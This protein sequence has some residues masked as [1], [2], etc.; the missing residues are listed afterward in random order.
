MGNT[1]KIL[2]VN[3]LSIISVPLLLIC[4]FLNMLGKFIE[5]IFYVAGM[6]IMTG[7]VAFGLQF[8]NNPKTTAQTVAVIILGILILGI[9]G[10]AIMLACGLITA[11]L[12]AFLGIIAGACYI[13]STILYT[14]YQYLYNTIL[15]EYK[16]ISN[17]E[18]NIKNR[19]ICV[20]YTILRGINKGIIIF[21]KN[22][23]KGAIILSIVVFS[24]PI[25][26]GIYVVK[27]DFGINIF[28]YL[29]MFNWY[30]NLHGIV[31]Y[32]FVLGGICVLLLKLGSD[33]NMWGKGMEECTSDEYQYIDGNE[34]KHIDEYSDVEDIER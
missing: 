14:G 5:Q 8:I 17:D 32:S 9:I 2:K 27:R 19:M 11:L 26:Y 15:E 21:F 25:I 23:I 30:S 3:L 4:V 29:G 33:W 10:E 16:Y 18:D 22:S 31:M 28:S 13:F 24:A 7:I 34:S 20:M 1:L 12:S 6:I